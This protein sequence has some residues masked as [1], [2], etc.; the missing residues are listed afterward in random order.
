MNAKSSLPALAAGLLLLLGSASAGTAASP[1][2]PKVDP[3]SVPSQPYY[4][5]GYRDLRLAA[6]A[7]I[8][9]FPRSRDD[10]LMAGYPDAKQLHYD[11]IDCNAESVDGKKAGPVARRYGELALDVARM[12]AEL[13]RLGYV[14]E[15]YH[16]LVLCNY[17]FNGDDEGSREDLAARNAEERA[18]IR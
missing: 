3:A 8:A 5:A 13:K 2:P 1:L 12:R 7:E 17:G 16:P 9:T 6:A 11:V 15:S 14:A 4:P 10:L 18:G